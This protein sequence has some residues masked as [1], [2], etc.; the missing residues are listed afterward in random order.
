MTQEKPEMMTES[1]PEEEMIEEEP[2]EM[3]EEEIIEEESTE[4]AEEESV[5]EKPTKMVEATNEKE[6]KE[7]I[8]EEKSTS[9]T[10]K[11]STVQAKKIAKQKEIQQKKALVKNIAK[12]MEKVDKDI[13]NISKNLQIKNIIKMQAMTNDQISLDS[14]NV[15]FYAPKDIYLDQLNL[16]DNRLIYSDKSLATYIQNDKIEI[17]AKKLQEINLKK[18]KILSELEALK[19]G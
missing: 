12:V 6:E 8:K 14:Y 5:E 1:F 19:N 15:A 13:K 10:A 4:M 2:T 18:Q 7:E 11:K 9:E 17:K 3:A 16:M